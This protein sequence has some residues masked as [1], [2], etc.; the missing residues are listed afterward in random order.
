MMPID[1]VDGS[2]LA[3]SPTMAP[4]LPRIGPSDS[5]ATP[6][7][8]IPAQAATKTAVVLYFLSVISYLFISQR[9]R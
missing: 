9:H 5:I 4:N 3:P 8:A 6:K 2:A 1:R 7:K